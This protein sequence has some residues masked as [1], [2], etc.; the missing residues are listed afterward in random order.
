[1]RFIP[2]WIFGALTT[3][4]AFAAFAAFAQPAAFAQV[5]PLINGPGAER[6]MTEMNTSGQ[7]GTVTVLNQG[8]KT[9]VVLNI[10]SEPPGN[11]EPAEI[12]RSQQQ[13]CDAYDPTPSYVLKPV[14]NGSSR[15]A[16]NAPIDK[17]LSGNYVVVVRSAEKPD[18]VFSCGHL[19]S[20]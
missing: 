11:S 20:S 9:G 1:M 2:A 19:Y 14:Q 16:V 4:A 3:L 15:S 18:H 5:Y 17:L 13:T 7:I 10:K 12:H 6:G 8:A